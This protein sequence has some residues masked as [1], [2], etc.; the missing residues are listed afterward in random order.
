MSDCFLNTRVGSHRQFVRSPRIYTGYT[1]INVQ[2]IRTL[3]K[4]G[5]GE[6]VGYAVTVVTIVTTNLLIGVLAGLGVALAKLIS[7]TTTL[8]V[9][10]DRN[11]NS[12]SISIKFSGTAIFVNL[13]NFANALDDVPL[14]KDVHL[15][16]DDLRCI[17]HACLNLLNFW[18]KFHETQ[19][20]TVSVDWETVELKKA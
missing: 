3:S 5:R 2:V 4:F 12:K 19:D 16:F 14:K 8:Q 17:D 10:V 18:K 1:L 15:D 11:K 9:S 20:G 6:V 13:P 7:S